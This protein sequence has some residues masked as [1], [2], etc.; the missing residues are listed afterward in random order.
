MN[1]LTPGLW[2]SEL[3]SSWERHRD[4]Q[5]HSNAEQVRVIASEIAWKD[6]SLARPRALSNVRIMR[7]PVWKANET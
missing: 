7:P 1:P 2:G 3:K 5:R 4:W 6:K